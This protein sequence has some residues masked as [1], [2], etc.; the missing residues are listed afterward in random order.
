MRILAY[1]YGVLNKK[2]LSGNCKIQEKSGL[3]WIYGF[4][5][6]N[7]KISWGLLRGQAWPERKVL[8]GQHVL[9]IVYWTLKTIC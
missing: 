4:L 9:Q 1:E 3:D 5:K 7:L 6:R 8:I 2:E